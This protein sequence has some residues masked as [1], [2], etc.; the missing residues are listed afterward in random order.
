MWES[1][2][3]GNKNFIFLL[4]KRSKRYHDL[5][6]VP[7]SSCS[8]FISFLTL[9]GLVVHVHVAFYLCTFINLLDNKRNLSTYRK[10]LH[11]FEKFEL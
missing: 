1:D 2:H 6:D 8:K 7:T 4:L 5:S 9:S 3:K 10:S 11:L